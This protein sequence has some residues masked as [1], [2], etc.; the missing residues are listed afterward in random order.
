MIILVT[1][2]AGFIGTNFVL[3]NLKKNG[4]KLIVYDK[5]TYAGNKKNFD[6]LENSNSFEFIKG[7]INNKDKLEKVIFEFMP[8]CIIN[9]AAETHVDNSIDNPVNFITTN[10]FG[11]YTLLE[12]IKK[13]YQSLKL[14]NKEKFVYINVSTDEVYGS[15]NLNENS[16]TEDS[17]FLPNSP[18][19]ASKASADH[20]VRSFYKTYGIPSITTHCSNN[21]G[22]FQNEEK[23]IPKVI[24]NALNWKE[25]PIYGDGKNV[26][27]WIF[28]EDHCNALNQIIQNGKIG[29]SYNIGAGTELSNISI[30]RL[31]CQ[32]LDK[33]V[34]NKKGSYKK[35]ISFVS[36]RAGHDF[37]YSV[38]AQKL[39]NNLSWKIDNKFEDQLEE[40]M[41]WFVKLYKKG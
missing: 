29:E 19:S 38:S 6:L 14:F 36:D 7:D 30:T 39:I 26:R 28:V 41:K 9:F 16:F 25:I 32:K 40:T 34:P 10:I 22:P 24:K 12:I 13:Y 20:L 5:L 3:N 15:L 17:P 27:D 18:Y 8:E 33:I 23:L 37:R 11:T 31:I 21:F 35:L 1:G 2:G 4:N